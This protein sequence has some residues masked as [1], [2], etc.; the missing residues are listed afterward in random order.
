MGRSRAQ[1]S[2][3][4]YHPE[5]KR[6]YNSI[7]AGHCLWPPASGVCYNTSNKEG[8]TYMGA[9]SLRRVPTSDSCRIHPYCHIILHPHGLGLT[10]VKLPWRAIIRRHPGLA[11]VILSHGQG[12]TVQEESNQVEHGSC[13]QVG[14]PWA[15][16]VPRVPRKAATGLGVALRI[17]M[18]T[19]HLTMI[20]SKE[21]RTITG[22]IPL[23]TLYL[24]VESFSR[25]R[26]QLC[27]SLDWESFGWS[28][29][30]VVKS[31][32]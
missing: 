10:S 1:G 2:S 6:P 23:C 20:Q 30:S 7:S 24:V 26:S 13:G 8:N 3:H 29:W 16:A 15:R 4:R 28:C 9:E 27:K 12:E 14:D 22:M 11:N 32:P 25:H 21:I 18:E 5:P 19:P 17:S 31:L